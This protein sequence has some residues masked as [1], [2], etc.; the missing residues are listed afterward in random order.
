MDAKA[1]L[2]A[3]E[4]VRALSRHDAAGA[5]NAISEAY[6]LDHSLGGLADVVHLASSEIEANDQVSAATWNTLA[7]AVAHDE[8]LAVV[9]GSRTA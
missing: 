7:D 5:R 4:A 1:R 2:A 9:E 8:L 6:D 3:E